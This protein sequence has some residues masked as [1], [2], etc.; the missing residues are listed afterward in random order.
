MS[1]KNIGDLLTIAG[2]SWGGFMGGFNLQTVNSNGSTGCKRSSTGLSG[3]TGDYIPHHSFFNYWASTANPTHA[4]PAS[5][6]EIGHTGPA[7]HQYDLQDFFDAAAVG[8]LPAVSFLKAVAYQDGHAGY[9]NPL[10][11]QTFLV[12]T[13]NFLQKL[14][15]WKS[16]AVIVLYDDSDGW[17]DH[18]MGPIVNTSAGA[19][20]AL[21]GP[22]TCGNGQLVLPGVNGLPA[23]GRCGYGPR[24]PFVVISP[25]ARHNFV[26]HTVTDQSSIIRFIEDNWLGGSRIGQGSFDGVANSITQMFDFSNRGEGRKLFLDPSTG[27]PRGD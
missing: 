25:W 27:T 13:I 12:N 26:D 20:D 7:N 4:R 11:E 3:P 8:N 18:Q 1:G 16:T 2:V 24:Q 5:L 15:T 10:D 14:P 21:T 22:G 19:A 17:Y 23:M 6:W 9:S